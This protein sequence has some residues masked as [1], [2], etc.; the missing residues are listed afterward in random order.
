[1][2][3]SSPYCCS[4]M[5]FA[6]EDT[7]VGLFFIARDP[8]RPWVSLCAASRDRRFIATT[9]MRFCP[10]CGT[11]VD[12]TVAKA[13]AFFAALARQHMNLLGRLD[14]MALNRAVLLVHVYRSLS[15][16]LTALSDALRSGAAQSLR[17]T[18]EEGT[19]S[20]LQAAVELRRRMMIAAGLEVRGLPH[21]LERLAACPRDALVLVFRFRAPSA[22]YAVFIRADDE[23]VLGASA[24]LLPEQADR[25]AEIEQITDAMKTLWKQNP[26]WTLGKLI[27][28]VEVDTQGL[29]GSLDDT[30]A[31][32]ILRG[33]LTGG[34]DPPS[35]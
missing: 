4:G 15:A 21:V 20:E 13:P 33:R 7:E 28:N 32:A 16:T 34:G 19:A 23:Q 17:D 2:N 31:L 30:E 8:A 6:L 1:M 9:G 26:S 35:R 29:L 25:E 3:T 22:R 12:E 24:L 10:A 18:P 5:R 27:G 14:R 11:R